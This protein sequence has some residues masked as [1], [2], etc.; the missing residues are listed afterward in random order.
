[1]MTEYQ[2]MYVSGINLVLFLLFS[3]IQ[4]FLISTQPTRIPQSSS[5][6]SKLREPLK[7]EPI[8]TD[9]WICSHHANCHLIKCEADLPNDTKPYAFKLYQKI[10]LSKSLTDINKPKW[11]CVSR[12]FPN[13]WLTFGNMAIKVKPGT[14]ILS[15]AIVINLNCGF[16]PDSYTTIPVIEGEEKKC[17]LVVHGKF[18][19]NENIFTIANI[20]GDWN[21]QVGYENSYNSDAIISFLRYMKFY[22]KEHRGHFIL[23]GDFNINRTTLNS[24]R[25]SHFEKIIPG[26]H[27]PTLDCKLTTLI[28]GKY[29][30]TDHIITNVEVQ[31]MYTYAGTRKSEHLL[32]SLKL[33]VPYLITP[34][35]S[36]NAQATFHTESSMQLNMSTISTVERKNSKPV[37]EFF[38][39][40]TTDVDDVLLR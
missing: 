29:T 38:D 17:I 25:Y 19:G 18:H 16:L 31:K 30:C 10:A 9:I 37:R 11:N 36:I 1:M 22:S 15:T 8:F 24:L 4:L 13:K 12:A 40:S 32:L 27:Y 23:A 21:S 33:R 39:L 6:H 20:H 26:L 3:L 34:W 14:I 2:K 28:D 35:S 7:P 5:S